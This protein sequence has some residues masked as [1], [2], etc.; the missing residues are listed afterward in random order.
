ME[1]IRYELAFCGEIQQIGFIQ[2]LKDI[3][4]T[5]KTIDKLITGFEI[6]LN[7]PNYSEF[8]CEKGYYIASFF[9]KKGTQVFEQDIQK[10]IKFLDKKDNGFSIIQKEIIVDEND[11]SIVYQDQYQVLLPI[12]Y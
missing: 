6:N 10:I 4:V 12:K 11:E 8:K 3:G 5:N 2:G 9:T 1:L 7:I